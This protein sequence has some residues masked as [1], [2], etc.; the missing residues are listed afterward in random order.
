MR[1]AAQEEA[2]FGNMFRDY[3]ALRE[4][5]RYWKKHDCFICKSSVGLHW[6]HIITL[7]NGGDNR[8]DNY[9]SLCG[10]CHTEVHGH[11]VGVDYGV[12]L[13]K[14]PEVVGESVVDIA[15]QIREAKR[16]LAAR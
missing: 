1:R 9:F 6:H 15:R 8:K 5:P 3:A 11:G 10:G 2:P 12:V 7:K 16:R 14:E 13:A 4:T